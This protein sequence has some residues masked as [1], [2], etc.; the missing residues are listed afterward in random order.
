[1]P[2]LFAFIVDSNIKLLRIMFRDFVYCVYL[3]KLDD[4]LIKCI[5]VFIF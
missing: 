4:Y 2:Y 3:T 5:H 1:M